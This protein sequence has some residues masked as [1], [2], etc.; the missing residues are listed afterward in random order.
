MQSPIF[1]SFPA[2]LLAGLLAGF[3]L[4]AAAETPAAM[5]EH[6]A[7]RAAQ[8]RPGFTPDP[9]RGEAF[10]RQNHGVSADMP[11]CHACH[12]PDPRQSGK[13]VITSKKIA[14]MAVSANPERFTDEAKIEKWFRRNCKEVLERECTAAEK[15]DFLAW[16]VRQ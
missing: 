7:Q 1:R 2:V 10:Y 6:Y 16:L 12:G 15:A 11:G 3:S 8:E 5:A 9:A 13:H 14:P 4:D